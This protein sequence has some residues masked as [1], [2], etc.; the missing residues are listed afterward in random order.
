MSYLHGIIAD[1]LIKFGCIRHY[2]CNTS[3][4]CICIS[5]YLFNICQDLNNI[6]DNFIFILDYFV[7]IHHKLKHL[8][9]CDSLM[10]HN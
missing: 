3:H 6:C 5:R 4:Y 8:P 2:F 10:L 7:C 1:V 9:H